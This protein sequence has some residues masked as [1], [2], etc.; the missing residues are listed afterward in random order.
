ML[1]KSFMTAPAIP[2]FYGRFTPVCV[3]TDYRILDTQSRRICSLD[4]TQTISVQRKAL[5][6]TVQCI[7][8]RRIWRNMK[9]LSP[10]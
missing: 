9:L 10:V 2:F 4:P 8:T 3:R 1:R 5:H 7:V 6:D